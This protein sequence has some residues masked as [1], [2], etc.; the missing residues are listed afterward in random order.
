M[1]I[2]RG[3]KSYKFLTFDSDEDTVFYVENL[4]NKGLKFECLE[5]IKILPGD[6]F[7]RCKEFMTFK[8]YNLQEKKD[9]QKVTIEQGK[10]NN[11]NND[12]PIYV[13]ASENNE[14]RGF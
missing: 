1:Y 12:F 9:E 5:G 14:E 10:E 4:N 3:Q 6:N 7:Y 13:Y 2:T 8:I 11:Y